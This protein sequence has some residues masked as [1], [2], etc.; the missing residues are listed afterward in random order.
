MSIK[1]KTTLLIFTVMFSLSAL[2][3]FYADAGSGR[4]DLSS[5]ATYEGDCD[6][7]DYKVRSN[8]KTC[9]ARLRSDAATQAQIS[10]KVVKVEKKRGIN[11]PPPAAGED[12]TEEMLEVSIEASASVAGCIT[13]CSRNSSVTR[14]FPITDAQ[15]VATKALKEFEKEAQRL[16]GE[17]A[18]AAED[19]KKRDQCEVGA[20]NQPL[21]GRAKRDCLV[22]KLES[23]RDPEAAARFY[24]E[25]IKELLVEMIKSGNPQSIKDAESLVKALQAS[26]GRNP[27][28]KESLAK[29]DQFGQYHTTLLNAIRQYDS[30]P[31]SPQN[32]E[33]RAKMAQDIVNFYRKGDSYFAGE[34][35]LSRQLESRLAGAGWSYTGTLTDD[36]SKFRQELENVYEDHANRIGGGANGSQQVTNG[37]FQQRQ[38]GAP[39]TGRGAFATRNGQGQQRLQPTRPLIQGPGAAVP[40]RAG[41]APARPGQVN[42]NPF[43]QP[44]VFGGRAQ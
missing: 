27:Y 31:D 35:Q 3:G 26:Q 34:M 33:I 42:P 36:I 30:L 28:L 8:G 39:G 10:A 1:M 16:R 7:D 43:G 9:K 5:S 37:Q 4:I 24:D 13:G 18:L 38:P 32:R 21:E 19:Q 11:A 20:D 44:R 25:N 23:I 17:A 6:F 12:T 14:R 15:N 40:G 29:M 22:R 2:P 41:A